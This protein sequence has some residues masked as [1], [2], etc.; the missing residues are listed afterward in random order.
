M[1]S[2][3]GIR[4]PAPGSMETLVGTILSTGVAASFL[5]LSTGFVWHWVAAG[6]PS[7]DSPAPRSSIA[8]FILGEVR[9]D[10]HKGLDPIRLINLGII[11]L[12]LTPY[13]RVL[14]SMAYFLFV[15]RNLKYATMTAFVCAVL[16]YSLFLR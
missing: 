9:T 10:F 1:E 7:F 12:L 2:E 6:N 11:V 15:L 16:T 3:I 5:L 8:L 4:K 13:V 14:L